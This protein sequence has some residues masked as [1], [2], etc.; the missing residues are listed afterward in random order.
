M[1]RAGTLDT[2]GSDLPTMCQAQGKEER[3]QPGGGLGAVKRWTWRPF[4]AVRDSRREKTGLR[5]KVD[6]L[7]S[8]VTAHCPR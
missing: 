4:E 1:T 7:R 6:L 2:L 8:V 3:K 5:F